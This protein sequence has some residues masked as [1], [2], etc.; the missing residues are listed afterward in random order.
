MTASAETTNTAGAQ[1]PVDT[2]TATIDGISVTV[3]K[4]T[5][6]IR[7]AELIGVEI[8]RFCDH[9]LLEPVGMCRMCLVE[10]SPGPPKPQPACA[11]ALADGMEVKTQRTS[12]M[13]DGAQQGVME[14]ILAN[15]PLDCPV[16]DKGG[17]CPLQNQ[18]MTNGRGESRF[19]L[20]KAT[21]DKPINV[22]A[23]V[24]LDRE[25][26]VNCARCTR[27]ADQ[28]AGDPFIVLLERGGKQQVG[29]NPG[30]PFDSYFSGNTVQIC[31]VGALTSAKYRF[32]ARPFDLVSAPTVCEHCA[33]GCG[34]RTDYRRSVVM[35]R[36][37][38]D[39]PDVNEEWNCDKGRFAFVYAGSQR[40]TTPM[41]RENGAL[42]PAS[43]PEAV[44]AAAAGLAASGAATGVL[45]GG[46]VT[47]ED[48][49]AYSLFARA[50]L[51]SDHVDFRARAGSAEEAGF[52][53]QHVAG[54]GLGVSYADLEQAPAVVLVALEPEDESPIVF[55]RLR[56]AV[57]SRGQRI[58]TIAPLASYGSEKLRAQVVLAAPGQEVAA[59]ADPTVAA[60]LAQPGAVVLVGERAAAVPGLLSATADLV[61]STGAALG[62]VPRRAGERAAVDAGLLPG[63]LP[64]GRPLDHAGSRAELAAVAG[65]PEDVLPAAVGLDA[66]AM[67]AA[68]LADAAAL[69]QAEADGT[70]DDFAP[71][72]RALVVGGVDPDDTP[73]GAALRR[74]MA[75]VVLP[76]ADVTQK[77]GTFVDWEG[78][79]RP[80]EQVF[81]V[82]GALSDARVLALVADA[83]AGIVDA[84]VSGLAAGEAAA[85]WSGLQQLSGYDGPRGIP[86]EPEREPAAPDAEPQAAEE[87][88]AADAAPAGANRPVPAAAAPADA[89]SGVRLATWR[90]LIDGGALQQGEP[91]LAAGAREAVAKVSAATAERYGLAE[92]H[93]VT[94]DTATGSARLA[95]ELAHMPDDVVWVPAHSPG[96]RVSTDLAAG[97]GDPVRLSAGGEA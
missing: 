41:I 90:Q 29:I 16:C 20:P 63:L 1:P 50:V 37:A 95:V 18:A 96:L 2:V 79:P 5:M 9:P 86:A 14:F 65:A 77:S 74:A 60:A 21:F 3:P 30:H 85:L 57:R 11:V 89:E 46:R 15:H 25:R 51:G 47:A 66:T 31:P 71:T 97:W 43:W 82:S 39:Q 17:E 81:A 58:V 49:F 84:P 62:W 73:D 92:G 22:S 12:A 53:A 24:L 69:A 54:T 52:L 68:I 28:I 42:R 80:F 45:T 38:D 64:G 26:C 40:L 67:V 23:Q 70:A 34:L 33:S 36:L 10:V 19:T 93:V 75:E 55:L 87:S 7:A 13:A 88:A 91:Y 78:R 94:I 59:L 61:A 35:R 76:V 83:I 72:L 56:K 8:P 6:I 48:A 4:G 27:F 44:Q 32:R